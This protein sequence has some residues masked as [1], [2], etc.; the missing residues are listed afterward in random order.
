[1]T[2]AV[3]FDGT[4][5]ENRFPDIGAPREAVIAHLKERQEQGD[6]IILW[7]CREKQNLHAAVMWCLHYGLKFDAVND[8]LPEHIEEYGDNCRKV[9]ADE[10]WDDKSVIVIGTGGDSAEII[11]KDMDIMLAMRERKSL[12]DWIISKLHWKNVMDESF[13]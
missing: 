3:D 4:I 2:I 12:K 8:N 6:K 5:C 7:T 9:F 11:K 13:P 1:M 10:Y